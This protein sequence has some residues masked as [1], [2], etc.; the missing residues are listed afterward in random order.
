MQDDYVDLFFI[1]R[2]LQT[3]FYMQSKMLNYKIMSFLGRI[4]YGFNKKRDKVH[5]NPV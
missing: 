2:C 4:N 3:N 1:R 5:F